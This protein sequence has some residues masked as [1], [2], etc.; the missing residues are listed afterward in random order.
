METTN[1]I[2]RKFKWVEVSGYLFWIFL[3]NR[4]QGQPQ[5]DGFPKFTLILPLFSPV[6]LGNQVGVGGKKGQSL[7]EN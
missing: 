6:S 7:L 1:N 4:Y 3:V 2:H 5:L